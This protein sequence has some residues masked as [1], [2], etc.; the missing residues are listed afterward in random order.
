M[1]S[2]PGSGLIA[3]R[4]HSERPRIHW[5]RPRHIS[6]PAAAANSF[7]SVLTKSPLVLVSVPVRIAAVTAAI[8]S[9]PSVRRCR[10][11]VGGKRPSV[12]FIEVKIVSTCHGGHNCIFCCPYRLFTANDFA[13]CA[14][15]GCG[16][17]SCRG[18]TSVRNNTCILQCDTNPQLSNCTAA[19]R[20]KPP[21][22]KVGGEV[23]PRVSSVHDRLID[24]DHH[25]QRAPGKD[26]QRGQTGD[27][28]K[29][30]RAVEEA[31]H[32]QCRHVLGD[33]HA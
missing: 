21:I 33:P 24:V 4:A 32:Q 19:S 11:L 13:G 23:I 2:S 31:R 6:H 25:P 28:E 7:S 15:A 17:L 8:S 10:V 5:N 18:E 16:N 30:D 27:G 29:H 20:L 1:T 12:F 22:M 3:A 26:R 9:S 14:P